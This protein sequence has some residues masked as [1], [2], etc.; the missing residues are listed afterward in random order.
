METFPPL[1]R[2]LEM[3]LYASSKGP[4]PPAPCVR[5]I[6]QAHT[7]SWHGDGDCGAGYLGDVVMLLIEDI[8][9]VQTIP[10]CELVFGFLESHMAA[11]TQGMQPNKGRG[12][13]L[14][15]LSNELLR[16]LSKTTHTAFGGRRVPPAFPPVS[17]Q[18]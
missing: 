1:E 17:P 13:A 18:A 2:L 15:R 14:L 6:R 12:L 5:H 4:A 9:E 8:L 16:R 7:A 10:S 3:A 11:L